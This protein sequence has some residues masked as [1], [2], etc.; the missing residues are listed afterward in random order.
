[1]ITAHVPTQQYVLTDIWSLPTDWCWIWIGNGVHLAAEA[2]LRRRGGE[3]IATQPAWWHHFSK[4]TRSWQVNWNHHWCYLFSN[5]PRLTGD[6]LFGTYPKG[7]FGAQRFTAPSC[8]DSRSALTPKHWDS[9]ETCSG[10]CHNPAPRKENKNSLNLLFAHISRSVLIVISYFSIRD[11]IRNQKIV[12]KKNFQ[13][14]SFM[15]EKNVNKFSVYV[16]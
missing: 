7:E 5:A 14:G 12:C 8:A 11:H 15:P 3:G 16:K 4:R 13:I 10:I 1:M 6:I 2:C 9:L